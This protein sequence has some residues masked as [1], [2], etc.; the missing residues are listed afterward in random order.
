MELAKEREG[1][2]KLANNVNHCKARFYHPIL[3]LGI[4]FY[5]E[6]T[7]R[8]KDGDAFIYSEESIF[9]ARISNI[10]IIDTDFRSISS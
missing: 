1:D 6:A 9:L 3:G 2:Y 10:D 7:P 5:P 8:S 4:Q